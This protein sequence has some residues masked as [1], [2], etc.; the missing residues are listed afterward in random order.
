MLVNRALQ[1][2]RQKNQKCVASPGYTERPCRK[3]KKAHTKLDA[4]INKI[5]SSKVLIIL[6]AEMVSFSDICL[7]K[8]MNITSAVRTVW[9]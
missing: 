8:V 7:E 6:L 4:I 5:S 9:L 2:L 1:R 3:Q